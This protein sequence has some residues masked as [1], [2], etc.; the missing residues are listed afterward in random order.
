MKLVKLYKRVIRE[1]AAESCIATFGDILF[2]DQLGGDEKNTGIE[3]KHAKAVY[4]FTDFDFGENIKPEVQQ[5]IV[6]LQQCMTTY[7]DVLRPK[8]QKVFRG[9]SAPI[10]AF[11]K[12]HKMP[13]YNET[14]P[15]LYKAKSKVQSW[16]E[17]ESIA[18]SFG[19]AEEL[20][21]FC[22]PYENFNDYTLEWLV[23]EIKG[24][25]IPIILEYKAT[26]KDFMF[27][28]EY[29]NQMSEFGT[30]YEVIR[31]DDSPITVEAYLNE[32]H[33]NYSARTLMRRLNEL[34][35]N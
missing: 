17:Y 19:E 32:K 10:M 4:N 1:G 13:T 6:D 28:G 3:N 35:R 25:K 2:A 11:I 26:P 5:V 27:K 18:E 23:S 9:T 22:Q 7:P 14:A 12:N 33:L 24:F 16:T 20:N 8:V 21:E 29:L 15:L 30:E 31:V 34:M